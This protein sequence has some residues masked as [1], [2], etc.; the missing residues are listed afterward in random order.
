MQ[1]HRK[2]ATILIITK[3]W[4]RT[5]INLKTM[6]QRARAVEEAAEAVAAEET[7]AEVEVKVE[8]VA[9]IAVMQIVAVVAKEEEV[10]VAI[11]VELVQESLNLPSPQI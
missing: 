6:E 4:A 8:E 3:K 7:E 11:M 5:G 9:E 1:M 2:T 10:A